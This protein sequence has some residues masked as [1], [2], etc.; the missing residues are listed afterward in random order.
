[1]K[2]TITFMIWLEGILFC[3]CEKRVDKSLHYLACYYFIHLILASFLTT[4][5]PFF[6]FCIQTFL[7]LEYCLFNVVLR[8]GNFAVSLFS[9]RTLLW[10]FGTIL[11][12]CPN[13]FVWLIYICHWGRAKFIN[14]RIKFSGI[15]MGRLLLVPGVSINNNETL[16]SI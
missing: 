15:F 8:N 5:F 16:I 12:R 3:C 14:Y 1:M 4:C 7:N 11:R 2:K 6:S 9:S 10:F 13:I